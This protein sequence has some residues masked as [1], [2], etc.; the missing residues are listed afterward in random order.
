MPVSSPAEVPA[1]ASVRLRL[2]ALARAAAL[3]TR[4]VLELDAGRTGIA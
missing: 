4:G 3:V 1:S 2:A